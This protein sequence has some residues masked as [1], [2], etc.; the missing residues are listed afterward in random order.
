MKTV[1]LRTPTWAYILFLIGLSSI[2]LRI[3]LDSHFANS[4]L[5]YIAVPF[6]I[7]FLMHHFIGYSESKTRLG[8]YLNDLRNATIIM[9][10][11]SAILFEGFVCVVMFMP[12]YYIGITVG[13]FIFA[14][15]KNDNKNKS[16][17]KAYGIPAIII[18][19]TF[20]GVTKETSFQREDSATYSAVV[21]SDI[22]TL[23]SNMAKQIEF[24]QP[25]HWFISFFPLPVR[26]EADSLVKGDIHKL[27]FIYNR[28][29]FTNAHKGQ[30]HIK[31]EDVSN[32]Y[33]RTK[34][35][36]NTS[37]LSNYLKIHGTKVHFLK[38]DN[39]T[40]KV[41]VTINYQ[42]KLDPA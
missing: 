15:P 8:N 21:H 24:D 6:G 1:K 22:K 35:V 39:K 27:H 2:V 17:V 28:W 42:R 25:R 20:E 26:I 13:S 31:I 14:S 3:L 32:N 18:L 12:I 30:M 23:K 5:V 10:G 4:A 16:Y 41:S 37:Y 9:F 40:T 11:T 33:V 7:S 36:K 19:M 34:I 29:F 38:V